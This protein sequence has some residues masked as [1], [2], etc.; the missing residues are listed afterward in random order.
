M[1]TEL[2]IFNM[3]RIFCASYQAIII[4]NEVFLP[5]FLRNNSKR[6]KIVLPDLVGDTQIDHL[7]PPVLK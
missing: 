5:C 2:L 6:S 7:S 4:I 1:K 3:N